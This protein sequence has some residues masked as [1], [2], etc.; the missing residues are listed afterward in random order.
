MDEFYDPEGPI[1]EVTRGRFVVLGQAHSDQD[2][3]VGKD[4]RLIG[5]TVTEWKERKGHSL[6]SRMVT[7]VFDQDIEILIIGIGVDGMIEVPEE[8]RQY[9][10]DKG[11]SRLV[12]L[13]TPNACKK[14]NE[15]HRE[16]RYVA[17]LAHGTC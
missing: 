11:I 5:S 1:E 16:G 12:L 10:H 8:T 14:Y 4:I 13:R 9:I 2:E 7:G 17:L 15:L 3:G 6:I